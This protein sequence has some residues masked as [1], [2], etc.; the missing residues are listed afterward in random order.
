V[1]TVLSRRP[2]S[3]PGKV[4]QLL[5]RAGSHE[6]ALEPLAKGLGK[7]LLDGD[8]DLAAQLLDRRADALHHLGVPAEHPHWAHDALGRGRLALSDGDLAAARREGR[9]AVRLTS[10]PA[11][12]AAAHLLLARTLQRTGASD[13]AQEAFAAALG[14]GDDDPRTLS[15]ALLGLAHLLGDQGDHDA[16]EVHLDMARDHLADDPSTRAEVDLL[17]ARLD[18]ATGQ[19]DRAEQSLRHADALARRLG[20]RRL[21]IVASHLRGDLA[22][23][24][25]DLDEAQRHYGA[26]RDRCAAQ[27]VALAADIELGLALTALARRDDP[28]ARQHLARGVAASR[29]SM[30]AVLQLALQAAGPDEDYERAFELAHDALQRGPRHPD[31]AATLEAAAVRAA[32]PERA[33]V[34][35]ALAADHWREL[36]RPREAKRAERRLAEIARSPREEEP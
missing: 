12:R 29:A 30:P 9:R 4:G 19:L 34:L 35:W 6:Q 15:A 7:A 25:G 13:A 33:R 1:A 17:S 24:R 27:E 22:R 23:W 16:A 26:A 10:T 14:Q 32:S 36:Q 3:H 18:L 2:D 5:A 20:L 8:N 28:T 21:S 31:L 11:Q